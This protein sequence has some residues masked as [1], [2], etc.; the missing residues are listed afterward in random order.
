MSDSRL[1]GLCLLWIFFFLGLCAF[2]LIVVS[3]MIY[4]MVKFTAITV[5]FAL[6]II[7][8]LLFKVIYI[9]KEH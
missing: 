1:F 7:L 4:A 9:R 2:A 6:A 8:F 3:T 5:W